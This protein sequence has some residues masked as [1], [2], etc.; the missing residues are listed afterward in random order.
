MHLHVQVKQKFPELEA[1]GVK[2]GA[3]EVRA[4]QDVS[5]L[6]FP[7]ALPT[8]SRLLVITREIAERCNFRM[9]RL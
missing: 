9:R 6:F 7:L 3:K 5:V 1:V 8:C 4:A 2:V